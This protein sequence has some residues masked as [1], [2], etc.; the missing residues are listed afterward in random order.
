MEAVADT[1]GEE[2]VV[3]VGEVAIAVEGIDR[4]A[5]QGLA[6][7]TVVQ[8]AGTAGRTPSSCFA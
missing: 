5:V 7:D 4:A 8:V 1:A 3:A 6:V 2:V